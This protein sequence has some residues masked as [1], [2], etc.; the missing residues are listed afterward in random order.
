MCGDRFKIVDCITIE[1]HGRVNSRPCFVFGD[2]RLE[3][4]F[5]RRKGLKTTVIV[6]NFRVVESKKSDLNHQ[7]T[8]S[9]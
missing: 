5:S 1:N 8:L 6:E 9:I 2:E 3:G 4:N 7:L